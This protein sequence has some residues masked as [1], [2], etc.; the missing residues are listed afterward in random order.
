MPNRTSAHRKN[1]NDLYRAL[2]RE[3]TRSKNIEKRSVDPLHRAL[4]WAQNPGPGENIVASSSHLTSTKVVKTQPASMLGSTAAR[5][6]AWNAGSSFNLEGHTSSIITTS[7]FVTVTKSNTQS[8]ANTPS[9]AFDT[10]ASVPRITVTTT[11]SYFESPAFNP[12]ISSQTLTVTTTKTEPIASA[13]MSGLAPSSFATR[14]VS[15]SHV[16]PAFLFVAFVIPK[17]LGW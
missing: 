13:I 6:S 1:A 16:I 15:P 7:I 2:L 8:Y 4:A 10:T 3:G 12:T 9:S 14:F 5:T 11:K 17:V